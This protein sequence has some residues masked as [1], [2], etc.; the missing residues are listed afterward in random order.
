M[1][2]AASAHQA[3][4]ATREDTSQ[5]RADRTRRTSADPQ[6]AQ[7]GATAAAAPAPVALD[8]L[9]RLQQLANASPQVAQLR[10]LQALADGRFA[11]VAQLAGGPEEEELVQGKFASAQLQPQ[12]QQAPRANNTGLPDQLESGIESLSGMSMDHVGTTDSAVTQLLYDMGPWNSWD[13]HVTWLLTNHV[14][15]PADLTLLV[16]PLAIYLEAVPDGAKAVYLP[17]SHEGIT[18]A[19]VALCAQR[20]CGAIVL[21]D[22][23][24]ADVGTLPK[25][26]R[27]FTLL[28]TIR[29]ELQHADNFRS[30]LVGANA[31]DDTELFLDEVI[32]HSE[33][34]LNTQLG[35]SRGD[36]PLWDQLEH[37]TQAEYYLELAANDNTDLRQRAEKALRDAQQRFNNNCAELNKDPAVVTNAYL[38]EVDFVSPGLARKSALMT[39]V[40]TADD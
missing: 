28:S 2:G 20:A 22:S 26:E 4:T 21:S 40:L 12:L 13:D 25:T 6:R 39:E 29:H 11:P 23:Y 34:V 27:V 7:Q 24:V 3:A 15:V 35:T 36:A 17:P 18:A 5:Q 9:S 30:G 14:V 37:L 38:N 1:A 8:S 16:G 10:R 31:A 32:A 19:G 33:N